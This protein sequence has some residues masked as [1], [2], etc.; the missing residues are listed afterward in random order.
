MTSPGLFSRRGLRWALVLLA[1][2]YAFLGGLHT[3][4]D[5]DSGWLMAIGRWVL[6]HR[7]IPGTDVLSYTSPGAPWHYPPLAGVLLYAIFS[8]WSYTGLSWFCALACAAVVALV[9]LRAPAKG[10]AAPLLAI[11]AVPSLVYRTT[12]RA[13]LFTT[14]LFAALL[15]ELWR[16]H[17]SGIR[18]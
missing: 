4:G 9:I 1:I 16:F 3:I 12:P 15:T 18:E 11:L 8:A 13:D 5:F 17:C 7:A 6:A 2:A 10:I 14:L